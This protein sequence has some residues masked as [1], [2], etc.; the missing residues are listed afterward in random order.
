MATSEDM[1]EEMTKSG[2]TAGAK[3]IRKAGPGL[4]VQ[5]FYK[6]VSN[7]DPLLYDQDGRQSPE[8]DGRYHLDYNAPIHHGRTVYLINWRTGR[9]RMLVYSLDTSKDTPVAEKAGKCELIHEGDKPSSSI[10][11]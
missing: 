3:L 8:A 6:G 7:G 10:E 5:T 4:Y 1:V 11:P 2:D 9:Y